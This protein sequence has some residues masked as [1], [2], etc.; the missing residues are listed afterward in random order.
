[1]KKERPSDRW[2]RTKTSCTIVITV[3][4]IL[5]NTLKSQIRVQPPDSI[6]TVQPIEMAISK[7][8][9]PVNIPQATLT[10]LIRKATPDNLNIR[11]QSRTKRVHVMFDIED[12]ETEYSGNQITHHIRLKNGSGQASI[13]PCVS[14]PFGSVCGPWVRIGCN[15]LR[16][17][18]R[19]S[20]RI[21]LEE[22]YLIKAKG[23]VKVEIDNIQC[24]RINITGLLRATG[25]HDHTIK[26]NN[27]L[28]KALS[29]VKL[30]QNLETIWDKAL[31]PRRISKDFY[32][33][34]SPV[35]I[36]YQDFEFK[37]GNVTAGI[38]L[39]FNAM[40]GT[41]TD[42]AAFK[43]P[44]LPNR[45]T[46][47]NNILDSAVQINLPLNIS[48]TAINSILS[49]QLKGKILRGGKNNNKRYAK[50]RSVTVKGSKEPDYDLIVGLNC[51]VLRTL[52][53]RN[54]L[55]VFLH[56]KFN[57]DEEKGSLE[58]KKYQVDSKTRSAL[59]NTALES[60][61]NHIAY[62]KVI[63]KLH[64]DVHKKIEGASEKINTPLKNGIEIHDG[65]TLK[66]RLDKV[67]LSGLQAQPDRLSI[68]FTL[69][70][71]S[72]ININK[73]NLNLNF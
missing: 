13:R 17:N 11:D 32:L 6:S 62:R 43:K 20:I 29:K 48:Y 69:S 26:I 14:T 54:D 38:G 40:T 24:A 37:N 67:S 52:F 56:V 39:H 50:I 72:H 49:K 59:F 34:L 16:A 2:S 65:I 41:Q 33:M 44:G 58:V 4:L 8:F 71:F 12:K 60:L 35:S 21:N 1:M 28:E 25:S 3:L 10:G 55:N 63:Q 51:D 73:L 5:T 66:G 30:K 68:L 22:N 53:R 7:I 45:I 70:A 42:S 47:T 23:T 46:K 57:Y 19:A 36:L 64:L 27:Q 15:S 9:I 18:A 31:V 61:A